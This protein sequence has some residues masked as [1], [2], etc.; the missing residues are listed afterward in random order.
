MAEKALAVQ[1]ARHSAGVRLTFEGAEEQVKAASDAIASRAYELFE[2][3]G[4]VSGHDREDWLK[5]EAQLLYPVRVQ[6]SESDDA[7]EVKAEVPGFS[8]NDLEVCVEPR[9]VVISGNRPSTSN[10]K[11]AK[12]LFGEIGSDRLMK[13]I[14]LPVE[15]NPKSASAALRN[16]MVELSLPKMSNPQSGNGVQPKAAA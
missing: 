5:A 16:G 10:G 8:E 14:D 4:C 3:N 13:V 9:R 12:T 15:V 2:G 7:V 11:K 6:A 1:T